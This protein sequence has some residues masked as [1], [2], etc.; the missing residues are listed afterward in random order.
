[1][2]AVSRILFPVDFSPSARQAAPFV[3]AF[4]GQFEASV[5]VLHV[6]PPA[7][8]EIVPR[9]DALRRAL[10]ILKD[11]LA[12]E[13]C[14]RKVRRAVLEGDPGREIVR[15]AGDR[16]C[17]LVMMPACGRGEYR[18]MLLGSVAAKV[19]HDAGCPV[20]TA[21]HTPELSPVHERP[22]HIVCGVD[23]GANSLRAVEFARWLAARFRARFTL[24]HVVP[25]LDPRVEFYRFSPQWRRQLIHGSIAEM[26]GLRRAYAA[27]AEVQVAVGDLRRTLAAEVAALGG[28]LL[29]IGRRP[30]GHQLGRLTDRAYAIIC[31][32]PCPVLSV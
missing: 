22:A 16:N 3:A 10:G 21:A 15:A 5:S 14:G 31:E 27:G 29:V 7:D 17:D 9:P 18:R 24:L 30:E 2:H 12:D 28:D 6:L 26:E 19:L 1:M 4:A 23:M 20:W 13:P 11:F 8:E 25:A 32:S